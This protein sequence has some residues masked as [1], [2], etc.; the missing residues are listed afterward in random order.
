MEK[1]QIAS[2]PGDGIGKETVSAGRQVLDTVCE[3]HG[4]LL[5]EYLDIDWSC[6][7]Y[8]K[9]GKMMP[10]DGLDILRPCDAIFL[11]AVGYPGEKVLKD[12]LHVR[13][14]PLHVI[15]AM[16]LTPWPAKPE[17]CLK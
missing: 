11:G 13:S 5:L 8:K 3:I 4:G 6:E 1:F 17:K 10:D 2:I 15:P 7:Y 14:G 12:F 9:N 16:E